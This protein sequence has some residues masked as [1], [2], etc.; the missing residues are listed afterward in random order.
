MAFDLE[1]CRDNFQQRQAVRHAEREALRLQAH[2]AAIAVIQQVVPRYPQI[3][4]VYLFG[5]VVQPGQFHERSDVDIAVAGTDAA[6]YFDLWRELE[7]VYTDRM[8]DLRE[9]NA[10]SHFADVVRQTGELIYD[11]AGRAAEG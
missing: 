3:T 1:K 7:T 10:P 8:I 11:A 2:R 6:A 9:I 4:Q 5:S